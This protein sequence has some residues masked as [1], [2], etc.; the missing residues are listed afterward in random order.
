MFDTFGP[1]RF[2]SPYVAFMQHLSFRRALLNHI[3]WKGLQS[4]LRIVDTMDTMST[5][6]YEG[7]RRALAAGDEAVQEQIGRGKDIMSILRAC[8]SR[9]NNSSFQCH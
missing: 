5:S 9:P 7:K 4:V 1:L 3:P 8:L 2:L 6:V